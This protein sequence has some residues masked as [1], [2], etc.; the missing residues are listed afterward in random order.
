MA[1]HMCISMRLGVCMHLHADGGHGTDGV[2][3]EQ[4]V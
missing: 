1:Q 4:V 3:V 2:C